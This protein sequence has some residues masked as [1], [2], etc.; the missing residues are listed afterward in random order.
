MVQPKYNPEE[1]L[2]RVKLMMGYDLKKTL[3]ENVN[4]IS[5]VNEQAQT[6]PNNISYS[7]LRSLAEETGKKAFNMTSGFA[8]MGSG[9]EKARFILDAVKQVIGKN[10]YD[11]IDEKCVPAKD[12]FDKFFIKASKSLFGFSG[13]K[14]VS[15]TLG[16]IVSDDYV[17]K[18]FPEAIRMVTRAKTLWDGSVS[19]QTQDTIPPASKGFDALRVQKNINDVFCSVKDGIITLEGSQHKGKTW[20]SW[21]GV[22]KPTAE[23]LEKAKKSCSKSGADNS[24][25]GVSRGGKSSFTACSGEY[26]R[27]CKSDAIRKVQACLGMATKYQ[28]G[29]FGPITQGEL[30]KIGKGFENGFKDADITTICNQ[31]TSVAPKQVTTPG[32]TNVEDVF[33]F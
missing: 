13:G 5:T 7:D 17:K 11:D 1:A 19:K 20:S 21:V 15:T 27:G 32:E 31:T 30:K 9:E 24:G 16:N 18:N 10:T 2:Q 6:C 33:N 3:K 8:R 14:N 22:Y 29:N 25:G 28:T 26:K 4:S 12:V 23:Q